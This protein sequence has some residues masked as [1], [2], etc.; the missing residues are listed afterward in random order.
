VVDTVG[1]CLVIDTKPGAYDIN[2]LKLLGNKTGYCNES[3]A[4]KCPQVGSGRCV[5]GMISRG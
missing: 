3:A 4:Q 2:G 5:K 1:N